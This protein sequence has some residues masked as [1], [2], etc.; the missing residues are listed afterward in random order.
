MMVSPEWT[1]ST[2]GCE[3]S[4]Q[5]HCV[6]SSVAGST[7]IF[8]PVGVSRTRSFGS[9]APAAGGAGGGVGGGRGGPRAGRAGGAGGGKL[10]GRRR[11]T[12]PAPPRH[13]YTRV[14]HTQ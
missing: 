4:N 3:L 5:P 14:P 13:T 11:N 8:L 10:P 6:V 9:A 2:G 1:R 12:R 7:C